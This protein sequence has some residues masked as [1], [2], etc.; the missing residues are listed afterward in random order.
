[1]ALCLQVGFQLWDARLS[2]CFW[3]YVSILLRFRTMLSYRGSVN[4]LNSL[5]GNCQLSQTSSQNRLVIVG[6]HEPIQVTSKFM[7]M[8]AHL[9]SHIL[10]I[11]SRHN[12]FN[13]R[14]NKLF[15]HGNGGWV[16]TSD[17]FADLYIFRVEMDRPKKIA[18]NAVKNRICSYSQNVT[19]DQQKKVFKISV[20]LSE[21]IT[22]TVF[23]TAN[24]FNQRHVCLSHG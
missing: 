10:R 24:Y 1:M 23:T 14:K 6:V 11:F 20:L 2:R 5:G 15:L 13:T 16:P 7:L 18:N 21:G 9:E 12:H 8:D 3:F 4:R 19:K 17:N 22:L